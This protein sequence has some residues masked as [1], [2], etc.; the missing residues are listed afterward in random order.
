MKTYNKEIQIALLDLKAHITLFL[1]AE[2]VT[3]Q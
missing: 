2:N 1:M 3:A